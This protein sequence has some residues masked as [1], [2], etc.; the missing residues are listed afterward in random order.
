MSQKTCKKYISFFMLTAF[1]SLFLLVVPHKK[2]SADSFA[3]SSSY[4][5][6]SNSD[7][8]NYSG[9]SLDA[10]RPLSYYGLN[11]GS[12]IHGGSA[13][14]ISK[15]ISGY[16]SS[17]DSYGVAKNYTNQSYNNPAS[18]S[19]S[20]YGGN[21]SLAGNYYSAGSSYTNGTSQKK[22]YS[23]T[24]TT[25]VE[26]VHSGQSYTK[27]TSFIGDNYNKGI[28]LSDSVIKAEKTLGRNVPMAGSTFNNKT[29]TAG[30]GYSGSTY[31]GET[32]SAANYDYDE[33]D[34]VL[35]SPA[36]VTVTRCEPYLNMYLGCGKSNDPTEITKLQV[37]L[38]DYE[39]HNIEV[40]GQYDNATI[41]AVKAFQQKYSVDVLKDSWGVP[42][43]TG[44]TYITTRAKIN[45]IV[46]K[47]Q[48]NFKEIALPNPRPNY[49][50]GIDPITKKPIPCIQ[51]TEVITIDGSKNGAAVIGSYSGYL[52]EKTQNFWKKLID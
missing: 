1:L 15:S 49:S 18:N 42:C 17:G 9:G 34:I 31:S 50:C 48:T 28:S 32:Y 44:C 19:G 6:V 11:A 23:Y 2:V 27:G 22:D 14:T 4:V 10:N 46:C 16:S 21:V 24:G 51:K 5:G 47:T 13:I 37:F 41:E 36:P 39:G 20:S 45:D 26:T 25:Y 35:M 40:N 12:N 43:P 33:P 52:K 38:R 3:N 8:S 30:V 29:L 7:F